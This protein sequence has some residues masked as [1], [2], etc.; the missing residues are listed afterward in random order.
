MFVIMKR[1][2]VLL[3]DFGEGSIFVGE[4]KGSIL[5]I[6]PY[7]T[8]LDLTNSIRPQNIF[9]AAFLLKYSYKYF[10]KNTIFLCVVDP[11][12][13]SV[14]KPIAIKS[15]NYYFVG[16][17]NGLLYPAAF[18]DGI[19]LMILL[20]NRKYF[21]KDTSS[22][23]HGRD[24]FAPVAAY[25][26][27]GVPIRNFGPTISSIKKFMLE[28]P[29]FDENGYLVCKVMYIDNFGNAVTNLE[30]PYFSSLLLEHNLIKISHLSIEVGQKVYKIKVAKY[31]C[32]VTEGSPLVLFNSF[33]LL[34]LSI[35]KGDASKYFSLK[36]GDVV[37]I[38]FC[39]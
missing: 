33:G 29:K 36:E 14:R 28:E 35:N 16:P 11:E 5:K 4:M 37:K 34:E 31:Y 19:R 18:I 10:P 22:T 23:F 20:E 32:E 39:K 12:V 15:T 7:A 30:E 24:I 1:P 21:F 2:I 26:S 17:D 6:N 27:K 25:I 9:Q 13:G 8:I 3:T 38:K